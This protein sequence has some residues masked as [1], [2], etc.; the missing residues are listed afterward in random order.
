MIYPD[1]PAVHIKT[2][3]Q[4]HK[5]VATSTKAGLRTYRLLKELWSTPSHDKSQWYMSINNLITVAGA[6]SD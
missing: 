1:A 6:V 5:T 4:L 2:K 3:I